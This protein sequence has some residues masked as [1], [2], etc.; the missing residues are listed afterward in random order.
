MKKTELVLQ[1]LPNF[2][3][4]SRMVTKKYLDIDTSL[5]DGVPMFVSGTPKIGHRT[6]PWSFIVIKILIGLKKLGAKNYQL[7]RACFLLFFPPIVLTIEAGN[8]KF[9]D[10]E[11]RFVEKMI[12]ELFSKKYGV[13]FNDGNQ[14]NLIE[15]LTALL[16]DVCSKVPHDQDID[17]EVWCSS[18]SYM[19]LLF[20]IREI[21]NGTLNEIDLWEVFNISTDTLR[22]ALIEQSVILTQELEKVGV[23][24]TYEVEATSTVGVMDFE[25]EIARRFKRHGVRTDT[26]ALQSFIHDLRKCEE[27]CEF[28]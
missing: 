20:L 19:N 18:Y 26:L 25:E 8:W 5:Q 23:A 15:T 13:P 10:D 7:L 21:C 11:K 17:S 27:S 9:N 12:Y 22:S 24:S 2:D 1:F 6:R 3:V 28:N 14:K 16:N 4:I